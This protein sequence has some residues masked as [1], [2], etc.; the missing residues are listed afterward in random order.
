[1]TQSN[2]TPKKEDILAAIARLEKT[3]VVD[4]AT[5]SL[6]MQ[7][8]YRIMLVRKAAASVPRRFSRMMERGAARVMDRLAEPTP[9][10]IAH[11]R[12]GIEEKIGKLRGQLITGNYGA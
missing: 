11:F 9:E 4:D 2:P 5:L 6:W 7:R 10:V 12:K 3:V 1:M 8:E